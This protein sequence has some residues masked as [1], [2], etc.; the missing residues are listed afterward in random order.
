MLLSSVAS[1]ASSTAPPPPLEELF[2]SYGV[3]FGTPNYT[4]R[5]GEK[6]NHTFSSSE[7]E[8]RVSGLRDIMKK[9]GLDAV[10]LTSI[11]NVKYFSDFLYCS[12][13]RPYACVVTH[14][15]L[16]TVSAGIDAGQPWRRTSG[17]DNVVFTDWDRSN[18][19]STVDSLVKRVA[20]ESSASLRVGLELDA[21]PYER[22]KKFET[23]FG[24][25]VSFRDVGEQTM[26]FRMKKS[27][28]EVAVIKEAAR[29]ADIGGEICRSAIAVGVPEHE[30]ALATTRAM[31][32]EI[33]KSFPDSEIM[34]TWTWF[35][36]GINTD[37]AHNPV[38]TRALQLGDILSLNAFPMC[39][40]Y[41]VAL[42]RTM[43]LGEPSP[44]ALRVWEANV[45]VHE[46]GIELLK[47]GVGRTCG[48]IAKELNEIFLSEN[49]LQ[50][51]SFGY[52]H[53]FGALC[54]YYGREAGLELRE[55][56][57]TVLEPGHVISMEPMVTIP[58]GQPGAGGFREHDIL[59]IA[60]DDGI[61]E[62]I[63]KFPY[64]PEHNIIGA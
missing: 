9:D 24:D 1:N 56:I 44:E 58:N 51:R 25:D 15:D 28:E 30:V 2:P 50:F 35:Q 41:Y 16:T 18:Y 47:N 17:G 60:E 29:I 63:T 64:G 5:N 36:S 4:F 33:A 26:K 45:K 8:R 48:S 40:G 13:G 43:F 39:S 57:E 27:K 32:R 19:W 54:H 14:N 7:M 12:F 49:L 53:S 21:L 11:H 37:G 3:P 22:F 59:V 42:E 31:V 10:V 38:T 46:A 62:D 6:A 55:D 52:G 61:V 23:A 34:D 20:S